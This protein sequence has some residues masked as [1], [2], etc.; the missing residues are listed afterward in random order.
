MKKIYR[1]ALLLSTL[2]SVISCG[3]MTRPDSVSLQGIDW[4]LVSINGVSF[5]AKSQPTLHF[6][7]KR[8]GGLAGCNR[9]FSSYS[10]TGVGNISF[11]S[12]ARTK[13]L[14]RNSEVRHIENQLLSGLRKATSFKISQGQLIIKSRSMVLHFKK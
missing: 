5:Q 10:I 3:N 7:E 8:A 12:I 1:L 11:G 2:L 13:M 9:Y 4:K 14:C 6:K